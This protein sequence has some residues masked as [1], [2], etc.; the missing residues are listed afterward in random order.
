MLRPLITVRV[1]TR[2]VFGVR[3][4]GVRSLKDQREFK[5]KIK[6]KIKMYGRKSRGCSIVDHASQMS[7]AIETLYLSRPQRY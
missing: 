7:R 6:I 3:A 4:E 5:I 2:V 1:R